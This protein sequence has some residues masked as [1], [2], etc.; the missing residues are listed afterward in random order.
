MIGKKLDTI[1][2]TRTEL[3]RLVPEIQKEQLAHQKQDDKLLSTVFVEFNRQQAAETAYRRMTPRKSPHMNPRAIST[4]P[5]EVVWK[6]LRIKKTEW[7]GRRI[8]TTTFIT[9]M[10]LFWSIPVA[11]VGAIRNINYLTNSKFPG[12]LQG[13][14]C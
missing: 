2:W 9:L 10:I 12:P 1:D 4:R 6:N 8:A 11:V 13:V 3:K 7:R 14:F 5:D